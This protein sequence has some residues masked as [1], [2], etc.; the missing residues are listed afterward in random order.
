MEERNT[1]ED[2]DA[3]KDERMKEK[4]KREKIDSEAKIRRDGE[5]ANEPGRTRIGGERE[6]GD[7]MKTRKRMWERE[8]EK[9]AK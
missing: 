9:Y 1:Y 2:A 8:N 7:D 5:R 6:R 3:E 4:R